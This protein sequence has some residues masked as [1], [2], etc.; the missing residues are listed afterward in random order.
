MVSVAF[1]FFR[2]RPPSGHVRLPRC[3]EKLGPRR[4]QVTPPEGRLRER[5]TWSLVCLGR[6]VGVLACVSPSSAWATSAPSPPPAW[7]HA[8]TR[9]CGVDVDDVKV[10]RDHGGPQPGRR[11]G[12]RRARRAGRRGGP[13]RATTRRRRGARPAPTC[14]WSASARRPTAQRQHRPAPTSSARSHD[15]RAGDGRRRAPGSRASTPS[16][17]AARSR[18]GPVDTVVAP[19]FADAAAPAGRSAPRCARSSCGRASGVADF[20]APPFVVVGTAD[21]A[22]ARQRWRELFAFLG[23]EPRA[24]RR[25][26]RAEALKYACNAF[27]ATKVSFANEM[28][29]IF[30]AYGVDSREVMRDLLRGPQAQHLPGLPAARVRLRRLVPAQGPALP[31]APG[32]DRTTSTCRCWPGRC[33]TNELVVRDVV[34]RVIAQPAR[35][36]SPARAELQDRHRRPAREPERRAGRAADRQGLRGPHLRPDHQPRA[37]GRGEPAARRGP[38]AAPQPAARRAPPRRR[39]RAPTSRSSSSSEPAVVAALRRRAAAAHHRPLRPARR[40]RRAAARLR[41]AR[42]VNGRRRARRRDAGARRHAAGAHHRAEPAGAL[43]PAGLAGVPGAARRRL[44]RHGGLPA[45]QGDPRRTRSLDGVDDPQLPAVRARRAAPPGSSSSTPTRSWR[46]LGWRCGPAARGR[47]DVVQA[48]NPPD[49]FWPLARWLRLR[50]GTRF[51]FDH[52]DLC[53]ELYDSRFPSGVAAAAAAACVALERATF[54]TADRVIST[55]ESYAQVAV[56]RGRQGAARTSRSSAPAPTRPAAGAA[57]R[58]A[59]CAAAA[60]TWWPTSA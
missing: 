8:A 4:Y 51:V 57:R 46:R 45:G 14:R 13:L 21:D 24:R 35:G 30:R 53:P 31:A 23:R 9:S 44:R 10:A 50:D 28:A 22:G 55:N 60:G 37:A 42:L 33:C 29:R 47:F 49:I 1:P 26:A 7:R 56:D 6:L 59:D 58:S 38:A 43:R 17:S 15:I 3:S 54:R 48:C 2:A 32:P 40:R 39:W 27:H 34:D 5:R 12:H 18:P 41:G 16:S 11:A 20:F 52:H 36:P 25:R 19:T